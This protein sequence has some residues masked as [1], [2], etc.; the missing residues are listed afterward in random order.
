M[1]KNLIELHWVE[2][3]LPPHFTRKPM[4]GGFAYYLDEVMVMALFESTGERSYKGQNFDF[5]LW[6]GCMFP[7][8]RE[9]HAAIQKRF[10]ILIN[11]PVLPKWMYLPLQTENFENFAA[12]ILKEIR[13]KS[14]LFGSIPKSKKKVSHRK[15]I[16]LEKIDTRRPR[17]FSDEPIQ[18]TLLKAKKISDLKNLGPSTEAIFLKAGIKSV[19]QFVRLGWKKSM[20]KLIKSNPKN[21]HSL[22][23]YALIG[24]LKNQQWNGISE[25]DKQE[26]REFC[27]SFKKK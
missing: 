12:E 6:N 26:A 7:A 17:M 4:F 27:A 25:Q 22:F 11:H 1:A 13:R 23:A 14:K 18:E 2:D 8:E 5:D 9:H 20:E 24:A 19:K 10:P 3:L 15:A 16:A 21:R